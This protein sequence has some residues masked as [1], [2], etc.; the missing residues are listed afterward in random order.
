MAEIAATNNAESL[1]KKDGRTYA[2]SL[3]VGLKR[4]RP[5]PQSERL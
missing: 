4:G 2:E 5:P 3:Q 1:Q